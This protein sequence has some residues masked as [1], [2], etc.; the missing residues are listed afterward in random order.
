MASRG[1]SALFLCVELCVAFPGAPKERLVGPP[2]FTPPYS[3]VVNKLLRVFHQTFLD[4][5]VC[6]CHCS[7]WDTPGHLTSKKKD[8]AQG[9]LGSNSEAVQQRAFPTQKLTISCLT[10]VS[11]SFTRH[12]NRMYSKDLPPSKHCACS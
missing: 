5:L 6:V 4:Q 9:L 12:T 11:A 3:R 10:W 2:E 7:L 1:R 8:L